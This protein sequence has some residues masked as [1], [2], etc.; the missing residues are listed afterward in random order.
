MQT[1]FEAKFAHFQGTQYS[2]CTSSGAAALLTSLRAAGLKI[3]DEVIVPALTFSATASAAML[4]GATP[5]IVDIDPETYCIDTDK[6]EKALTEKTRAIIP[7]HL[8]SSIADMDAISSIA[9]KNNL[10][11]I[12]DCAHAHGARWQGKGVGSFGNLGCFSFQQYKVMSAGEGGIITTKNKKFEELCRSFIDCGRVRKEDKY[13]QEAIGWNSRITEF[14]AAILLGQLERLPDQIKLREKNAEYLSDK[15]KQI[16]GISLLRKDDR[17]TTRSYYYYVFKY[18]SESFANAPKDRFIRAM[19]FEG[20]PCEDIYSPIH[21][22]PLLKIHSDNWP[23]AWAKNQ[24]S[25]FSSI[26]CPDAEKASN[27]EGVAI[28]QVALLGEKEDIDDVIA[29]I[30]KIKENANE[31]HGPDSGLLKA[32]RAARRYFSKKLSKS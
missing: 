23:L 12:E 27:N 16:D 24:T 13:A 32:T 31:L 2:V 21:K 11:V 5:I 30:E 14:Q 17:V 8:Y 22:S 26:S 10:Q 28:S 4:A 7:V 9:E 6:V 25:D 3:G 20:I 18:H 15:L 19:Y 29:A 1:E